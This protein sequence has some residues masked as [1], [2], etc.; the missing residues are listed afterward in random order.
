VKKTKHRVVAIVLSFMVLLSI[1]SLS[2]FAI[3]EEA[4]CPRL[5]CGGVLDTRTYNESSSEMCNTHP[6]Q[7]CWWVSKYLVTVT[8]C[9]KCGQ[10]TEYNSSLISVTHLFVSSP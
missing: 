8:Q 5:N 4:S 1:V 2:G 6:M 9:K 10:V 3:A 7:D